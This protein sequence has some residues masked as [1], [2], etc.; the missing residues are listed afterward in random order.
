MT[1]RKS[2]LVVCPGRGTYNKTELGYL[3]RHH[4][5]RADMIQIMEDERAR[6]G[7]PSLASLDQS[8]RYSLATHTRGDNASLLIHA[9]AMGDFFSIDRAEY[10]IVA[11]TGNSMGW[12][13]ALACAGAVSQ[14]T[15]AR[16]VNTMGTYMQEALIGGQIVYPLTD[17]DWHPVRDR[18]AAVLDLL[19]ELNEQP[20]FDVDVS[21]ELGGM[22]VLAGNE[23]GLQALRDRL[24]L[25]DRFPM[26]LKNH[27]AF[28]TRLQEPISQRGLKTF[29]PSDFLMP[30]IPMIDGRGH[31]WACGVS[32]GDALHEYTFGHQV[33]ET[34]DFTRAIGVA[35]RE[36]AP[37]C[38][39]VLGPGATLGGAVAQSL[40]EIDWQ[41]LDS[42]SAFQRRQESDPI[43][44]AM[45]RDDQRPLVVGG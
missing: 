6:L 15:G 27:A 7:Q 19:R 45:G 9:C 35:M 4:G 39:I 5:G 17:D 24:E 33:T 18:R 32:A 3:A 22:I 38:I 29:Q 25:I 8:E 21:I 16:I 12:Y 44:L 31:I 23:Q 13:V 20:E 41:G 42:K 30:A 11:V 34:Y 10:E 14:E 28:H 37:D 43:L 1:D 26:D 2:A 36:F 40:I